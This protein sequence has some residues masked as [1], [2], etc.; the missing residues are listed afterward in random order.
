MYHRDAVDIGTGAYLDATRKRA[1]AFDV[2][3]GSHS[4][5][6]AHKTSY[7]N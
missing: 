7:R 3:D 4:K 2:P 5:A 6:Q 1:D